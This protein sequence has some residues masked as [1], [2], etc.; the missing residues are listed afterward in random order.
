MT[1]AKSALWAA[2]ISVLSV[3][4]LRANPF[5]WEEPLGL[6]GDAGDRLSRAQTP[7]PNISVPVPLDQ[8]RG[9]LFLN[10]G[11]DMYRIYISNPQAFSAATFSLSGI[12]PE[13]DRLFGRELSSGI[14]ALPDPQL[15]LFDS[16]GRGIWANDDYVNG[17]TDL[18]RQSQLP[19][20]FGTPGWYYLAI[21]AHGRTPFEDLIDIQ[22][23]IFPNDPPYLVYGP[24][25]GAGPVAGF[26][27]TPDNEGGYTILLTGVLAVG[28][29]E[30][31]TLTVFGLIG[32]TGGAYA[33]VR[34]R[35]KAEAKVGSNRS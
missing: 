8:I 6:A 19:G 27:G 2:A 17:Q 13:F 35:K 7:Y 12:A 30:P 3:S 15:F 32:V 34:S 26:R 1:L 28:I 21:S 25:P 5:I 10:N 33:R 29:P 11:V 18:Y 31:S 24:Y 20:F 16:T 22:L 14:P 9:R 4:P 23:D